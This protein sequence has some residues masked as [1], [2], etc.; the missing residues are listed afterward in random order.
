MYSFIPNKFE[1]LV[2]LVGFIIRKSDALPLEQ[3]TA[4]RLT[5]TS[6]VSLSRS[7]AG[8]KFKKKKNYEG[9]KTIEICKFF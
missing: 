6:G 3:V 4:F 5:F 8:T 9:F 2:Y 7:E 1:K